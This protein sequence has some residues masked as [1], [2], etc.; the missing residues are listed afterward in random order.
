MKISKIKFLPIIFAMIFAMI[1]CF[2]GCGKNKE[3]EITD[4]EPFVNDPNIPANV[5]THEEEAQPLKTE[6]TE[7]GVPDITVPPDELKTDTQSAEP[8]RSERETAPE[9]TAPATEETSD[10]T[11]AAESETEPPETLPEPVWPDGLPDTKAIESLKLFNSN[12]VHAKYIA[13]ESFDGEVITTTS[14][15][16]FID[17][18][19]RIYITNSIKRIVQG[20]TITVID[21][22]NRFYM[23]YEGEY[24][25]LKFGFDLTDYT[26][27]SQTDDEEVYEIKGEDITSTWRFTDTDIKVSD[28]RSD[29]SFMLYDIEALDTDFSDMDF[30]IPSD[31]E[32]VDASDYEMYQ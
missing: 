11:T 14:V 22:D 23:V 6:P 25:G 26:L 1:L 28:R 9:E 3:S 16:Y 30:M 29:G 27:V 4:A 12:Y 21:N 15:E 13:A 5:V 10:E 24:G 8:D 20:S 2:S 17:G 19:N 32:Q 31:Y 7:A 18:V